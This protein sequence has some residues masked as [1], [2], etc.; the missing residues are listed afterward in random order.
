MKQFVYD[1]MEQF[2]D[3]VVPLEFYRFI[4]PEGMM[5]ED[6]NAPLGKYHAI[7]IDKNAEKGKKGRNV[8]DNLHSLFELIQKKAD[9]VVAPCLYIGQHRT[10][11]N[12]RFLNAFALDLDGIDTEENLRALFVQIENEVLPRPTF[13][14]CS[15]NGL[16]LYWVL[17]EPI[18]C[19]EQN[20]RQIR[21][22]KRVLTKM[23][24]NRHVT[25][26]YKKPEY[27]AVTQAMRLVGGTT[28]DGGTVRAF[29]TGG[30][31]T[32]AY[33]DGFI[34]DPKKEGM[35][36]GVIYHKGTMPLS[37]ARLKYEDWYIRR[38]VKKQPRKT[39]TCHKGLYDWWLNKIQHEAMLGHRYFC[40][41]MLAV[42]AIKC[43]IPKEKLREDAYSLLPKMNELSTK[44][45]QFTEYDIECALKCYKKS[46]KTFPIHSIQDLTGIE[47]EK[48]TRHFRSRENHLELARLARSQNYKETGVWS[49]YHNEKRLKVIDWKKAHPEG[50]K[51]DCHRETGVSRP[52]IDRYWEGEK[53]FTV[54]YVF[55]TKNELTDMKK[56]IERVMKEIEAV[57]K[58]KREE[59]Y[60]ENEDILKSVLYTTDKKIEKIKKELRRAN[61]M[62]QD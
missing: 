59:W 58:N 30:R 22:F 32:T 42:Y 52:T 39:W 49:R 48:R 44:D 17:T 47:V 24:W 41:M 45:N 23:V 40:V 6:E 25:T 53:Q 29:A 3:E 16:H 18:V 20:L 5:A 14:V 31:V 28:K 43:D 57:P 61:I 27:E 51:A 36:I 13:T 15:G 11:K 9:A 19:Y 34:R 21:K 7:A 8:Y 4:F 33:L 26:A 55:S 46:Y 60:K 54:E 2:Y 10:D 12:V 56:E 37:E 62:E 1:Y 38:V 35:K 50:R